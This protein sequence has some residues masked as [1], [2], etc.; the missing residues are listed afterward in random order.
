[1]TRR[2]LEQLVICLAATAVVAV[3][4]GS[5]R[6]DDATRRA[7]A[8]RL[9][10]EGVASPDDDDA[11]SKFRASA[12]LLRAEI[13]Q[14]DSAG[15]RFNR[16]NALLRG[17]ELGAAIAEY[18][19]A[20]LRAP[21]DPSI[22]ANLAEARR[23]VPNAPSPEPSTVLDRA[24]QAW[25]I[26][27]ERVRLAAASGLFFLAVLLFRRAGRSAAIASASLALALGGTVGLDILRRVSV[28]AAV[29][30]EPATLRKGNGDG[31][32]AALSDALPPGTECRILEVRP[33]WL[34]VELGGQLRGWVRDSAVLRIE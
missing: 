22:A 20:A 14:N 25:S 5:G 29:L 28:D 30:V 34:E 18:R 1:M 11:T 17:G 21:A 9:Y 19:A 26:A 6:S 13:A 32:D 23:K 24:A 33:G 2:L 16:A 27:S 12:E 8:E 31:F 10:A 4:L 3:V 7:E 15:A